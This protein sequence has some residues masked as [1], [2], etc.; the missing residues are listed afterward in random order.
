MRLSL[1]L[2]AS[3]SG[4]NDDDGVDGGVRRP[5]MPDVRGTVIRVLRIADVRPQ[6]VSVGIIIQVP[7]IGGVTARESKTDAF[8]CAS[9]EHLRVRTLGKDKCEST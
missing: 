8:G 5:A 6:I 3:F 9:D 1:G 2:P 4:G 7:R